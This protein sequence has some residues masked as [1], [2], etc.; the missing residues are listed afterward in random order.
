MAVVHPYMKTGT[1]LN[2]LIALLDQAEHLAGQF[3]G[4]YSG[5]FSSAEE[6]HTALADSISRLKSGD[7]SQLQTLNV[8][9]LPT[10]CWDEFTGND[11]QELANKINE[12]IIKVIAKETG[13]DIPGQAKRASRR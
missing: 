6:F 9:F 5:P 2:S 13:S 7:I 4:G 10:A 1:G 12:L 11:G 3:S 8:W